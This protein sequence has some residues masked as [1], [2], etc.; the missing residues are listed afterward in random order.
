MKKVTVI[1]GAMVL[2]FLLFPMILCSMISLKDAHA[3]FPGANGKIAFVSSRDGVYQIYVMNADGTGQT[4]LTFTAQSNQ[5]PAWSADGTKIAFFSER[6]IIEAEIYVMNADGTG[7][8]RL[9]NNPY[10]DHAPVWSPDGTKIAFQSRRVGNYEIYVMNADGTG[11]IDI[12]NNPAFDVSPSWSPDGTK[13]AFTSTREGGYQIWVMNPDGTGVTKLTYTGDNQLADWSPDGTR[14]VFV[15]WR[16]G[17]AEIYVMNSDGTGQTRLT[18]NAAEDGSPCWSPD[19]TKIAFDSLRDGN[20]EIYVMN[21]DGTE[22]TNISNNPAMDGAPSWQPIPVIPVD[23]DIKPGSFPNS[24]NLKSKGV[25]PVAVLTTADFDAS[26]IDPQTVEFAGASP[27]RWTMEDVDGDGDLDMLF[28]FK[29][30]E[31]NLTADSTEAT[32]T[33][34]TYAGVSIQGTDTV[35]IVPKG[36]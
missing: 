8:T 35:N 3:A 18:N 31:L 1:V 21:A 32:L 13:I 11:Q 29:T 22:Q 30:Q 34:E 36:K 24:I 20:A 10:P 19:G 28:H 15:S 17:N 12:S 33:G 27:V 9:T 25:V 4:R 14:I 7:Q 23:I 6:D 26:T 5:Y 2:A 16:D